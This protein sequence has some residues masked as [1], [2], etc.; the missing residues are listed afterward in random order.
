MSPSARWRSPEW[1]TSTLPSPA[2]R[3][4]QTLQDSDGSFERHYDPGTGLSPDGQDTGLEREGPGCLWAAA[5]VADA[6][7]PDVREGVIEGLDAMIMTS[8]S[9]L[10]TGTRGGAGLPPVSPD[11]WEVQ[12]SVTLGDHRRPP[13]GTA[14]RGRR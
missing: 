1:G 8:L 6:A 3:H 12:R 2:L 10:H 13:D 9:A 11:Y 4:L 7:G 14:R 5:E